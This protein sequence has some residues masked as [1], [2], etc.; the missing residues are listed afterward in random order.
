MKLRHYLAK[1]QIEYVFS[2]IEHRWKKHPLAS[3]GR[4][5]T[6]D[7]HPRRLSS[8]SYWLGPKEYRIHIGVNPIFFYLR[9]TRCL[10]CG[11]KGTH[12][13]VL[14][15]HS[16]V[17]PV[18]GELQLF[19]DDGMVMT[20]DHIIPVREQGPNHFKNY[21]PMCF[22]CNTARGHMPLEIFLSS[23]PTGT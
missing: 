18:K 10:K 11:C 19:T 7:N 23:V 15:D 14:P 20:K 22:K 21:T 5:M 1:V 12:F 8:V 9:G 13:R 17:C 6:L 3:G 16:G 4:K 2:V